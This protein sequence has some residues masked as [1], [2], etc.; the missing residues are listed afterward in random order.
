LSEE[1]LRRLWIAAIVALVAAI[2]AGSLSPSPVIAPESLSDKSGHF[3]AYF[4]LALLGSGIATPARL[5]RVMLRCLLLGASLEIA[6]AL[7]TDHRAAEWTD[8]LANTVGIVAAW[9]LAA[10]GRAGWGLRAAAWLSGR[11]RS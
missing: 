4:T 9:L 2:V 10:Q 1:T 3:L 7:L 8:L 6:Q 5:W 11:H